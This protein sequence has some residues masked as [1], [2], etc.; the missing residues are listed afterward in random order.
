MAATGADLETSRVIGRRL[1]VLFFSRDCFP[2]GL[3]APPATDGDEAG[4]EQRYGGSC[5]TTERKRRLQPKYQRVLI[6]V[7]SGVAGE[8][9]I[10]VVA[11]A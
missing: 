5:Y 7:C 11:W 2:C 6:A 1:A 9:A 10:R 4:T 3:M 8:E